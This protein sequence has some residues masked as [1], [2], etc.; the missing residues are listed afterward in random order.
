[1][2]TIAL[3]PVPTF[4]ALFD[5]FGLPELLIVLALVLVYVLGRLLLGSLKSLGDGF[6][7]AFPSDTP[8]RNI[9]SGGGDDGVGLGFGFTKI[10]VGLVVALL[11]VSWFD[12]SEWPNVEHWAWLVRTPA[13][14]LL[15]ASGTGINFWSV[16][17]LSAIFALVLGLWLDLV[18]RQFRR[19]SFLT[20]LGLLWLGGALAAPAAR[21]IWAEN[22]PTS[23]RNELPPVSNEPPLSMPDTPPTVEPGGAVTEKPMEDPTDPNATPTV[24]IASFEHD[25]IGLKFEPPSLWKIV[26]KTDESCQLLRDGGAKAE[27]ML[28]IGNYDAEKIHELARK[29]ELERAES[30]NLQMKEDKMEVDGHEWMTFTTSNADG[31]SLKVL[32]RREDT[33]LA[34]IFVQHAEG[35]DLDEESRRL[36]EAVKWPAGIAP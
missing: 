6:R 23:S 4:F 21:F 27:L 3:M 8:A 29:R 25:G 17:V 34:Q 5:G 35:V 13:M 10:C 11:A 7:L 26:G 32:V 19:H 28:E 36:A 33:G 30:S 1:M 2:N 18:V 22:A 20:A 15:L 24:E 31:P 9:V 16:L 14:N 12:L